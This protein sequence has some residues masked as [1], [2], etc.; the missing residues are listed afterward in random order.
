V[1]ERADRAAEELFIAVATKLTSECASF[2]TESEKGRLDVV[3]LE[4]L[5]SERPVVARSAVNEDESELVPADRNAVTKCN[6]KIND[7]EILGWKTVN[8]LATWCLG[9]SCIST[10]GEG[11]LTG[12]DE[13]AVF[14]AGDEMLVVAKTTAAG[15]AMKFLRDVR[16]FGLGRIRCVAWTDG[17]GRRV[18]VVERGDDLLGGHTFQPRGRAAGR[19]RATGGRWRRV[20]DGVEELDELVATEILKADRVGR[21]WDKGQIDRRSL[22]RRGFLRPVGSVGWEGVGQN[23]AIIVVVDYSWGGRRGGGGG[24]RGSGVWDWLDVV[25]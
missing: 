22:G 25:Q 16:S 24:G 12:I 21:G 20:F 18:W 1:K 14:C 4:R 10:E 23:V 7:I 13:C 19:P 6:I 3:V 17:R 5:E 15:E 8:C 9:D 11:E 2:G